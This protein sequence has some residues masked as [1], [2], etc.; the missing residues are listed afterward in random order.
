M[1]TSFQECIAMDLKFYKERILLHLIDHA[2]RL[3]VSS[4][5]RSKEPKVILKAIFKS[6]IQIYGAPEKFLT[7]NGGE[8]A[9]SKFLDMAESMNITVKVTAAESPF[10]N[11]IVERHNFIIA[12][13]M[14]KAL[15]ESQHLDMD[16]KLAWCLNAKNS[17]ANVH[18]FSPFQ[19]VFGQNPKLPSTFT[20]K[21]TALLQ[22]NTSKILT[23][24]FTA[25]HKARQAFIL[26]ESSEKIRR[27]LNNNVRTSGDT[28]Y[29]TRDSVYFN[30]I[31]EKRWKDPGKI[32]S[33]DGRYVL[34]KYGSNY[35]RVHPCRLS[36]ARTSYN[37][38]NPKVVQKSIGPSQIRD[39]HNSCTILESDLEDEI[40]QQINNYNNSTIENH[41]EKNIQQNINTIPENGKK[42]TR[43]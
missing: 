34:V 30:K 29:I 40:I 41:Q 32:L 33:Q 16:L 21:P 14:D 27:A 18:G 25:L 4:F 35:V 37:K 28:K 13:M 10:S 19:L 38:L 2:T 3:S 20:D 17:L 36:L 15:E 9:N 8:F 1:A 5:V 42:L 6:W 22:Y 43:D 39:K 24:N 26:S 11:E 12:D 31:N 7:D 23:D